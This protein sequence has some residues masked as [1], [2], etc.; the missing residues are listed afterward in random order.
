MGEQFFHRIIV[1]PQFFFV[2]NQIVDRAVA[3]LTDVDP[4]AHLFP[5]EPLFE[6]FVAV[7]GPRDEMMEAIDDFAAAKR[8][9]HDF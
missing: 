6:P 8:A 2:G 5:R 4:L 3:R 7:Q 9:K 1:S